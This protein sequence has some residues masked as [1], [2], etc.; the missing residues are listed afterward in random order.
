[1]V[2][3]ARLALLLLPAVSVA[4]PLAAQEERPE[5]RSPADSAR[6][7]ERRAERRAADLV[8][9]EAFFAQK[10]PLELT[11][12]F[13]VRQVTEDRDTAAAKWWPAVMA[14]REPAAG[15]AAAAARPVEGRVRTRGIFRLKAANCSFPPLRLDVGLGDARGTPLA[16]LRRPKLVTH[17]RP[18]RSE[19]EQYVLQ[20]YLVYELLAAVTPHG[21]RARLA[22]V[23]YEDAAGRERPHTSWGVIVE[24]D[25]MLERRLN[26]RLLEQ[27]GAT[28]AD[29]DT[30]AMTLAS[31]FQYM[32]GNTD[33]SVE[34]VH[35]AKLLIRTDGTIVPVLYDFDFAGIVNAHYAAPTPSLSN[36]GLRSVR[37]RA[38]QGLCV[39]EAVAEQVVA[40]LLS[41][42]GAVLAAWR[43]LPGL[44]AR[45][46]RRGREY[47]ED[48]FTRMRQRGAVRYDLLG[49]CLR[50]RLP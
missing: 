21:Y 39:P 25:E 50:G 37:D 7:A 5:R 2:A 38:F 44:E 8:A 48:F 40:T 30:T 17:C 27:H 14:A 35:N 1:V 29:V 3:G 42:Q 43:E 22:R 18:N 4:R 16:G 36:L 24:D 31:L 45:N 13:D 26:G 11:L 23:T 12:R 49:R 33:W 20:E 41:R 32:V 28:P 9:G 6:R 47:L 10:A 46:Y 34:R 19:Y 15:G